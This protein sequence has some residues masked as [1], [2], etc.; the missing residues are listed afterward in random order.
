MNIEQLPQIHIFAQSVPDN[1]TGNH[2]LYSSVSIVFMSLV[3]I[4]CGAKGW[5]DVELVC[6]AKK[7]LLGEY[8]LEE[9]TGVPSHDCFR[10][11][12]QLLDTQTLETSFRDFMG[13]I[14]RNK[15][16][17]IAIDGKTERGASSVGKSTGKASNLHLISAF[18]TEL[19]ISLGQV[20]VSEKKN[21]IVEIPELLKELDLKG[22][23]IT[24]DAMGCQKKIAGTIIEKKADYIFQVKDN[25]PKLLEAI[26]EGCEK[27][28]G[29]RTSCYEFAS[30][31]NSGH[32]REEERSCFM[33]NFTAWLPKCGKEWPGLKT[34]GCITTYVK[35]LTTKKKTIEKHYFISSLNLNAELAMD[36]IRKHWNIENNLHWQLDVSFGEDHKRLNK[37]A[38]QNLSV[39][40]K[41]A[42]P[43]LKKH[44]AKLSI[45]NKMK[46]AAMKDDFLEQ[47]I[48]FSFEMNS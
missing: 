47:L 9:F 40:N 34:F 35:N 43:I 24:I 46:S 42:L 48:S 17:V 31:V 26:Q 3:G 2:T 41:I 30:K 7:K 37:K 16:S 1:R 27:Q 45:V 22:D 10:Y 33:C 38:M 6:K 18:V 14:K 25:Q 20:A 21:E 28:V 11:F 29:K 4:L 39:L 12:F 44:P 19:G 32:S 5:T 13:S 36:S 8:L 15:Q 23:I